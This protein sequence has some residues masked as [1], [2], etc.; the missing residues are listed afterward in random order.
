M[1][2]ESYI[3]VKPRSHGVLWT[4]R[5]GLN[6]VKSRTNCIPIDIFLAML[7]WF[8]KHSGFFFLYIELQ[9]MKTLILLT[10]L[11]SF[12]TNTVYPGPGVQVCSFA[13]LLSFPNLLKVRLEFKCEALR[14][15]LRPLCELVPSFC[16]HLEPGLSP[17]TGGFILLY[18][19]VLGN[20]DSFYLLI[21][22]K[23]L[24]DHC[25]PRRCWCFWSMFQL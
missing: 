6:L 9:R 17:V 20:I 8:I 7:S 4:R 23:L 1:L 19:F 21:A 3:A 25:N 12:S 2:L 16:A 22:I 15:N 13:T 10:E 14:Y 18:F 11:G 5:H 24:F